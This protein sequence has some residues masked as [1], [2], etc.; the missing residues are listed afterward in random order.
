MSATTSSWP[1]P[2]RLST[3]QRPVL[4]VDDLSVS[5]RLRT[6]AF[7]RPLHLTAVDRVSF[8]IGRGE[9]LGLV[10]ESGSGKST[11]ARGI[12]RLVPIA[13]GTVSL[14]G[15]QVSNLERTQLRHHRRQMQM[16]FQD[17]YSSL[18]P[19]SQIGDSIAEPLRVHEGLRGQQLVDRVLQ[20]LDQ[21]GLG[22]HHLRRYPYEFSGGQR[23]R[24]AIARA[25]A[26]NPSLVICDEAVSALDVSTQNQIINLL[27]D[28][29]EDLGMSYLFIA[30]DLAVVRHISHRVAVLY[31]GRLIEQGPTERIYG[32][33]MHPYTAALL[34]ASP[35]AD[36]VLQRA[37]TRLV[38]SGDLPDPTHPPKG[39]PFAPRCNAVMSVCFE[40]MPLAV[41]VAGGG[42]VKCHLYPNA[43][44]ESPATSIVPRV[45]GGQTSE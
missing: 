39:C 42:E 17:P 20:L 8:Q 21:V 36:P 19:S 41:P 37:R 28:L 29:R 5:F 6:R 12:L 35:V 13:G 43:S 14:D 40:V 32:Q 45:A 24:I 11:T 44:A 31:L 7:R 26:V 9:T 34:S 30:H 1:S 4:E 2:P 15:V 3:G 25:I 22:R 38:I 27:E 23:Q 33:P 16:V 10:G 18:D